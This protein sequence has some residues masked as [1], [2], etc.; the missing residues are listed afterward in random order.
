LYLSHYSYQPY[1]LLNLMHGFIVIVL[2]QLK[3]YVSYRVPDITQ[4]Q[5]TARD[6]FDATYAKPIVEDFTAGK[7]DNE[8]T[9]R[10]I[11]SIKSNVE[12]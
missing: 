4:S 8:T 1:T 3:P 12:N 6:L 7:I 11:S 2:K 5:F 9:K 10:L